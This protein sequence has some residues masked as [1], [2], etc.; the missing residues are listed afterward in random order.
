M[1]AQANT[2]SRLQAVVATFTDADDVTRDSNF[3]T[4][5]GLDSL[6]FV[7]LVMETEDEFGVEIPD[8]EADQAKT[9]GQLAD[10]VDRMR[11]GRP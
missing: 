1:D 10:L 7:E 3:I 9:F 6:D 8:D 11:Q 4:D 5:L 2:E